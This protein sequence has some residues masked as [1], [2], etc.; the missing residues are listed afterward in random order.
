MVLKVTKNGFFGFCEDCNEYHLH[1]NNLFF[2]FNRSNLSIFC[3][4]LEEIDPKTSCIPEHDF[5]LKKNI[6]LKVLHP[7]VLILVDVEDLNMLK[8]LVMINRNSNA[9][10]NHKDFPLENNKN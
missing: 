10:L 7:N 8:N 5:V 9:S 1:F 4:Y 2:S 6:V 3:K